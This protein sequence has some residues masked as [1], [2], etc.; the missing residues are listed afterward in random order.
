MQ[1][2]N[3]NNINHIEKIYVDIDGVL[4]D[5]Q[6]SAEKKAGCSIEEL[7]K[8][9][10]WQ[11]FKKNLCFS[12]FFLE[13]EE[14]PL[15]EVLKKHIGKFEIITACGNYNTEQVSKMKKTW[16]A[17]TLGKEVKVHC[18]IKSHEKAN[19]ANSKSL[20]IDDRPKS[21]MPFIKSGGHAILFDNAKSQI[22]EIENI[23]NCK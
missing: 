22:D 15:V 11:E 12:D 8:Q 4:A 23:L 9:N 21:V 6:K 19:F 5:F 10:K 18:V 17:K 2:I 14:M 3:I 1:T 20:L 13:L 16:I 7:M